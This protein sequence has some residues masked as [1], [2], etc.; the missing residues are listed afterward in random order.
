MKFY[1]IVFLLISQS[2]CIGAIHVPVEPYDPVTAFIPQV[3]QSFNTNY[4]PI[5]LVEKSDLRF[6]RI[7]TPSLINNELNESSIIVDPNIA[8]VYVQELKFK[9]KKGIYKNYVYRL[10]FNKVPFSLFPFYLTTGK[11]VGLIVIVTFNSENEPVLITT[12]HTCGC[13]LAFIPTSFLHDD[14]FPDDWNY[15]L[16]KVYGK[17][18]PGLIK[19]DEGFQNKQNSK[20]VI[21]LESATHRVKWIKTESLEVIEKKYQIQHTHII[22]MDKLKMLGHGDNTT[23]F[24]ETSGPRKGYV[25]GSFK[26]FERLLMS[27]WTMDLYVGEDKDFGPREEIG[28]AFYTSLKFW[29]R[30][31]SDMWNF[32]DFLSYWGWNL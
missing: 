10:H 13:Y 25:K 26:L 11:N 5:F 7:G 9:T 15:T 18:L 6:N 4:T 16:Q 2:A 30:A 23:S 3:N 28:T 27:W 1:I 22:S 29:D 20:I 17:T 21:F 12:V 24:F 31:E 19:L 32:N 14:A 8:S